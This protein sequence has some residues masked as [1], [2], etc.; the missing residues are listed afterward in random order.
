MKRATSLCGGNLQKSAGG[1]TDES[2]N[3]VRLQ[4]RYLEHYLEDSC[5]GDRDGRPGK[6][7]RCCDCGSTSKRIQTSATASRAPRARGGRTKERKKDK[8]YL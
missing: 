5:D 4:A 6:S 7:Y 2:R 8:K 1:E 3:R